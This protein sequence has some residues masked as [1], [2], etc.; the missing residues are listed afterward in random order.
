VTCPVLA[1]LIFSGRSILTRASNL[2]MYL[3]AESAVRQKIR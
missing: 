1:G 3:G 2:L